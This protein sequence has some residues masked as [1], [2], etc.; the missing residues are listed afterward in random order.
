MSDTAKSE[1]V[2][3]VAPAPVQPAWMKK[4]F[5]SEEVEW[6]KSLR[7]LAYG[8]SGSGKT[9]FIGTFPKV[10][11]INTDEGLLTLKDAPT[12]RGVTIGPKD[13]AF[14]WTWDILQQIK[15]RKGPFS[16][17][18]PYGD[19]QT[20]AIDSITKL[21]K[22]LLDESMRARAKN[23]LEDK[24]EFDDWGRL[25]SRLENIGRMLQSLD[26][27][28]VITAIAQIEKN[29][30]TGDFVGG[31]MVDGRY[32]DLIAA[33][34]DE[35]YYLECAGGKEPTYRAHFRK[36]KWFNAKSR[37]GLREIMEDPSY[38]KIAKLAK[39]GAE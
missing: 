9:H 11:I 36:Y 26:M 33:D 37:L 21:S 2:K 32:R 6:G 35:S 27:N 10:F 4:A 18:G 38:E 29:D 14:S 12:F 5:A 13:P 34:F 16:S 30:V 19:T 22:Y 39:I 31:P 28:V 15:A 8:D 17:E 7:V 1:G 3:V 20:L 23:P 25:R 24:A